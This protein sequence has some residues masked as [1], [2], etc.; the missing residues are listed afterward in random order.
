MN[1]ERTFVFQVLRVPDHRVILKMLLRMVL[2]R[3]YVLEFEVANTA[4]K[5]FTVE[6]Q[7]MVIEFIQSLKCHIAL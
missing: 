5:Q 2:L 4:L 1:M 7:I 6:Y 3:C